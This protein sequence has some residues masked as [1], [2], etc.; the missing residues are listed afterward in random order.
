MRQ[1]KLAPLSVGLL[2]VSIFFILGFRWIDQLLLAAG[3][4]VLSL[5]GFVFGRR[6]ERHIRRHHMVI[7]G[8]A[9]AQIGRWGNLGLFVLS[10]IYF[11]FEL[12]RSIIRGDI[13][14]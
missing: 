10:G 3:V 12:A 13:D 6:A 5:L 11:I 14:L 9:A 2:L 4:V 1:S 8:Y 7:Q